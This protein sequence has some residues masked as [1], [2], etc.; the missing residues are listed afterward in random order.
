MWIAV[1]EI[2]SS[3]FT[4]YI[5]EKTACR[6]VLKCGDWSHL[7]RKSG[8][9][10]CAL[11]LLRWLQ[12]PHFSTLLHTVF[13]QIYC[14]LTYTA[15]PQQQR[16]NEGPSMLRYTYIVS[17]FWLYPWAFVPLSFTYTAVFPW[18][19]SDC[20]QCNYAAFSLFLSSAVCLIAITASGFC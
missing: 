3:C 7:S 5:W 4:K 19:P 10:A 12:S 15:F 17:T 9:C 6:R 16:L 2:S 20:S 1:V 13:S 18:H 8:G 14:F 11:Y